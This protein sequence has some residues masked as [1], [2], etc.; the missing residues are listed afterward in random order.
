MRQLRCA[1]NKCMMKINGLGEHSVLIEVR[2][3]DRQT[4]IVLMVAIFEASQSFP[5]H[6]RE[7]EKSTE[8]GQL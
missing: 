8:T 3:Q 6:R 5:S 4:F 1:V 2:S 7:V